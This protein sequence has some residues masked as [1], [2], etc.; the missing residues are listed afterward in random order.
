M[1]LGGRWEGYGWESLLVGC[2]QL[3]D[4]SLNAVLRRAVDVDR[5]P[6]LLLLYHR[7]VAR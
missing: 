6:L 3:R 5:P 4:A 1:Q 7:R 2:L